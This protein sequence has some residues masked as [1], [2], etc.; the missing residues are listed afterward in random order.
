MPDEEPKPKKTILKIVLISAINIIVM[1]II[2]IG[3]ALT[4]RENILKSLSIYMITIIAI[5]IL[6]Y[7]IYYLAKNRKKKVKEQTPFPFLKPEHTIE[8]VEESLQDYMWDKV[9]VKTESSHTFLSEPR[10][11]KL[12]SGQTIQAYV[13]HFKEL[14][15][16]KRR[17]YVAIS[18][19]N[20]PQIRGWREIK[21][22]LTEDD[23]RN[24]TK[25]I[26][27]QPLEI[28]HQKTTRTD[29]A[30]NIITEES[31]KP[32]IPQIEIMKPK[33]VGKL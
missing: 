9:G 1:V 10:A 6:I 21:T 3:F 17:E 33:E 24:F 2:F 29:P 15:S 23:I 12:D 11:V 4:D 18:I 27:T 8:E 25:Q 30:G 14:V 13:W 22:E 16:L 7:V 20:D 5:E 28:E 31:H 32:I 26:A 19:V